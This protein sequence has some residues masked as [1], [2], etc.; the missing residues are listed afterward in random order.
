MGEIPEADVKK[1]IQPKFKFNPNSSEQMNGVLYGVKG[2]A[3]PHYTET[4]NP[5][6][7]MDQL[8]LSDEIVEDEIFEPYRLWK[9]YAG[10]RYLSH[11]GCGSS[12]L[13][14]CPNTLHHLCG[15]N[16]ILGMIGCGSTSISVVPL[17]AGCRAVTPQTSK[18]SPPRKRSQAQFWPTSQSKTYSRRHG[19]ARL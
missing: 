6:V 14:W 4:G 12:T 5:S 3:V 9:L 7:G 13:A 11:T 17:Q 15:V 2:F 16:G 1:V 10:M 18:T 19:M 8:K